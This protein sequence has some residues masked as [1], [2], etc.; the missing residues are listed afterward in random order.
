MLPA[1]TDKKEATA[2]QPPK[3]ES[4]LASAECPRCKMS[5]IG[6]EWSEAV[7]ERQTI[8]LWHC[9]MCGY[10]F[11]NPRRSRR[12]WT[13]RSLS[14]A[15]V[16]AESDRRL[17]PHARAARVGQPGTCRCRRRDVYIVFPISIPL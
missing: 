3:K 1:K 11:E 8:H 4:D 9:S 17:R 16:S 5:V 12:A 10:E 2:C 7:D 13:H 15:G 14:D 6:D